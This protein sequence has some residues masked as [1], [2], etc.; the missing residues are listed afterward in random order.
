[1]SQEVPE[2]LPYRAHEAGDAGL[3][4]AI[5]SYK[6]LIAAMVCAIAIPLFLH[7]TGFD[8]RPRLPALAYPQ[9][10]NYNVRVTP[11]QA[12]NH[13]VDFSQIW[14]S[15]RRLSAGEEVYY[16]VDRKQWRR[17]WSSTY[18]PLI[19]W[20]YIPI[21]KLPFQAALIAHNLFGIALIL[22]C[23]WL[24]LRSA[25]CTAA[26]PA[27]AG[28]TLAAMYLT[29]TGLMHLERGQM[30]TYIAASMLCVVALFVRGGRSWAIAT[31]VLS[32]LKVQAWAFVGL[33]GIVAAALW[34]LRDRNLWWAP[35]TIVAS[36]LLF[37]TQLLDWLPSLMYVAENTSTHG[38]SFTRIL[39]DS[40]AFALPLAS[41][42][43]V[44]LASCV[45]LRDGGRLGD[46]DARR[47]LL[48]RISFP[49]AATLAIQTV[50]ATPVTHDYRLVALLGLL[51]ALA[52]WC[53]RAEPVGAWARHT[54]S[55]GYAAM[56]LVA[57]RVP[58]FKQMSYENTAYVLLAS[59]LCFL[60]VAAYL[61]SEPTAPETDSG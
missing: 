42:L 28:A 59:S 45:A 57:L 25:A 51:P 19:H 7:Y 52:I 16:P 14:L 29:P 47:A 41:S 49:L 54:M 43:A 30:D 44:G 10:Y 11:G 37:A 39:P 35:A 46:A 18:H 32:T 24:S 31:G 21:G 9:L 53:A 55:L 48:E 13:G 23:G 15:A 5:R 2:A 17:E 50:C 27:I 36:T 61:A 12:N 38:P 22:L 33:Y 56:L 60:A 26:F 34:G 4:I 40:A 8:P 58:P 1:M 3:R 20:L 6:L